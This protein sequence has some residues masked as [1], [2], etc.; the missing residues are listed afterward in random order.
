[1]ADLPYLDLNTYL[2]G[3]FGSRVQ[4]I[5]LD[6]G[7]TC[8]NRDGRVATGGCLYCNSRGSGTGAWSRGLSI[9]RQMEEGLARQAEITKTD[10]LRL[11]FPDGW[12]LVR[13]SVTE[14]VVTIR[15]E[16]V[17]E[18]ALGRILR[19]VEEASPFLHGKLA[20]G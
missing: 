10:G 17:D 16:G 18:Q 12:G 15:F 1:M 19:K 3:R 4:K 2:K 14:P 20:Q 11:E 5:G 7:L 13:P 8:P 6:A 9:N